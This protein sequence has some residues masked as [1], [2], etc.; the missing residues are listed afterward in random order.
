MRNY[1]NQ[2]QPITTASL[3]GNSV[4]Q[5]SALLPSYQCQEE[6]I[7]SFVLGYFVNFSLYTDTP[8]IRM[9]ICGI[10]KRAETFWIPTRCIISTT[11]TTSQHTIGSS[12][13]H[14]A[15]P[16]V[17]S[18]TWHIINTRWKSALASCRRWAGLLESLITDLYH[19]ATL[20]HTETH[21]HLH[22]HT[23]THTHTHIHKHTHTI[24]SAYNRYHWQ[25]RMK[26]IS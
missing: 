20:S 18:R 16:L 24:S 25:W 21:T 26:M 13:C 11:S 4:L 10:R 7:S 12:W 22:T 8:L 5:P 17:D 23:H 3:E 15:I 19:T 2:N 1:T 6:R 14:T 9:V